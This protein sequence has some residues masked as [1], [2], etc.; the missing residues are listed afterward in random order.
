ME[1]ENELKEAKLVKYRDLE[2]SQNF[3]QVSFNIG[4]VQVINMYIV[5]SVENILFRTE[6]YYSEVLLNPNCKRR[7]WQ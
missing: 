6:Y 3:C 1:E 4:S 5:Y 2:N 7:Y